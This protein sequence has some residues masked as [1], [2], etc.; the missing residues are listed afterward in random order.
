[1]A[2]IE[3]ATIPRSVVESAWS[4]YSDDLD[5]F[6]SS[7]RYATFY[8]AR[9]VCRLLSLSAASLSSAMRKAVR[10]YPIAGS[11]RTRMRTEEGASRASD[12]WTARS[13][14]VSREERSRNSAVKDALPEVREFV[15]SSFHEI[16]I[17]A[18][19][20]TPITN[21]MSEQIVAE[22]SAKLKSLQPD[23]LVQNVLQ[24]RAASRQP[25]AWHHTDWLAQFDTI[26]LG[27]SDAGGKT[28]EDI[29]AN[30]LE[31][32][33]HVGQGGQELTSKAA[34]WWFPRPR[35]LCEP[36][37]F[38][39]YGGTQCPMH[40][41]YQRR[42]DDTEHDVRRT[43]LLVHAAVENI[44]CAA[45]SQGDGFSFF[46][47]VPNS[48]THDSVG[49]APHLVLGVVRVTR[50]QRERVVQIVTES[51]KTDEQG[52]GAETL[53]ARRWRYR[54]VVYQLVQH[55]QGLIANNQLSTAEYYVDYDP[56]VDRLRAAMQSA[57]NARIVAAL[58]HDSV[59]ARP[60]LDSA[61]LVEVSHP[62]GHT[63]VF[64][65]WDGSIPRRLQLLSTALSAGLRRA[66]PDPS[67]AY[68]RER[69][70]FWRL[71]T[72]YV[73]KRFTFATASALQFEKY[74]KALF[75]V[76]S[77]VKECIDAWRESMTTA[78]Q[79][80]DDASADASHIRDRMSSNVRDIFDLLMD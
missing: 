35:L 65:V 28:N 72:L 64:S 6:C 57:R 34:L 37:G 67:S 31:T 32:L 68:V 27:G 21:G 70:M 18:S 24:S 71:L 50:E 56:F 36:H 33:R 77:D 1:M 49:L 47:S 13:Y 3:L 51:I 4:S 41:R 63:A 39:S 80:Q 78:V 8:G 73:A 20:K 42:Y 19:K 52:Q 10:Y 11:Q 61:D 60:P 12:Q 15:F 58:H 5:T 75:G 30:I 76:S 26:L 48:R 54:N 2:H 25:Y 55:F 62:E 59:A 45:G 79:R 16:A 74:S 17:A 38:V 23:A 46:V 69:E 40:I 53:Y 14:V 44:I 66:T 7:V 29:A 9:Q 43:A 22:I